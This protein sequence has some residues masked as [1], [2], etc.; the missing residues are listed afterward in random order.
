[1]RP[2]RPSHESS[3]TSVL[4]GRILEFLAS[5]L[6]RMLLLPSFILLE[7]CHSCVEIPFDLFEIQ[8]SNIVS[9]R[10][11]DALLARSASRKARI[12]G[13]SL[14]DFACHHPPSNLVLSC[15]LLFAFYGAWRQRYA[16]FIKISWNENSAPSLQQMIREDVIRLP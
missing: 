2:V 8:N 13:H 14:C 11:C 10:R 7:G 3:H 1:M 12:R 6:E 4:N 15:L 9:D 16:S 5:S